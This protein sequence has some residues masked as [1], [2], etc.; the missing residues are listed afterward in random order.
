MNSNEASNPLLELDSI[1]IPFDR[2]RAGHV[3]PAI[4]ALLSRTRAAIREIGDRT[5]PRTYATTLGALEDATE[6]LSR[7][8]G[9]ISHLEAVATTPELREAYNAVKPDVSAFYTSIPLDAQ[10]WSA[11]RSFAETDEAKALDPI[12]AR[13]LKKT[14]DEFRRAGAELDDAGKKQLEAI[15]VELST[16]TT[17]FSQNLLD[18]TNAFELVIDDE[19]KLAG[20][21]PSAVE[22]ARASA[23]QKG[24][25]GW[26]FT[27]QAPSVMAVLT[28]LDD[29]SIREKVWWAYNTRASSGEHD[30]RG[31]LLRI[32]ELRR[33]KARL[34]GHRDFADLV[35]EDRM[36]K[37]G[38]DALRFV[39]QLEARTREA[40]ERETRDLEAFRA[41]AGESGPMRP[42]DVGYWSEKQRQALYDFD[43]E[44]LRPYFRADR[45]LDGLFEISKRLYGIAV[46]PWE[47]APAWDPSVRTYLVRD[48]KRGEQLGAFYV[49]LHPRECKRGGAW[50]AGLITGGPIERGGFSPHLGLFCSNASSPV[51]GRPALLTHDEVE[52][53]FHEFG[54]LLH[55]LL[56]R[57]PVRSLAGTHVAWD[58][59]ELPSQIMENWTWEREAL[60]LFARHVDTGE[61]IPD[62]LFDRMKRARTYRA[63]TAQMR[64]LGF[65]SVD[66]GLHREYELAKHGDVVEHA[67][68]LMQSFSVTP[69]PEGYAM[70]TGFS[71]LFAHS[72]GYAAGYYSYKWA[73]VLDADAFSRFREAGLFDQAVGAEFRDKLLSRGDSDEPMKL[74][75]DFMG[76]E[77]NV[78]ALLQRNGLLPPS[79]SGEAA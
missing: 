29:G 20:L 17:K 78:E 52:T 10:L 32:L 65:A 2:I 3:R 35:L 71:H 8:M 44:A 14:I 59:V 61:T 26:R 49:D 50:M 13:H 15:D 56:S 77:P 42:W 4:D 6:D 64:Q 63:A 5:A 47:D 54:H 74:F 38:D 79:A 9:V 73:E 68:T 60:D 34:L 45:V 7:A 33:A 19:S 48:V 28:Y 53:L 40:F 16:I 24:L 23:E 57:V 43:E 27:L 41:A 25:S 72:V 11:L 62:E 37:T 18:S 30:N 51:N 55:H 22:A 75:V 70:I 58:F 1:R 21:P 46:E 39:Q 12:R 31:H 36:A 66:L 67:R 76:R 69:L